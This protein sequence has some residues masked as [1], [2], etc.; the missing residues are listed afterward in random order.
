MLGGQNLS[1]VAVVSSGV[2]LVPDGAVT[3][4]DNGTAL[5]TQGLAVVAG[6]DQAA[7]NTTTLV[8][9]VHAITM[10]YASASGNYSMPSA[11]PGLPEL[12]FPVNSIVLNVDN[13]SSD[14]T[15]SGS[16]PWAVAQADTSNADTII[17][18]AGGTG[19]PFAA[20]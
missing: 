11:P 20:P 9:G 6:Q 8:V 16:L 5:A 7:Y 1:V 4:Y 17:T 2:S 14:P 12:V 3:F 15:V 10:T 13:T 18:F 19:Q